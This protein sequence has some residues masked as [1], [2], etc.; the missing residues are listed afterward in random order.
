MCTP[1]QLHPC[2]Q[3]SNPGHCSL[4]VIISGDA[5][6]ALAPIVERCIIHVDMDCFFASV[7][8][9]AHPELRGRP[10]VVCHSN[11]ASASATGEVS[12]VGWSG[13]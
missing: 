10:M 8:A 3:N 1:N 11:S 9:A 4:P 7:A 2:V 13:G 12:W 6:S 5:A